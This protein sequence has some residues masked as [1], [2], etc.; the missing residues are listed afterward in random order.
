MRF[1]RP[2]WLWALLLALS[3]CNASPPSPAGDSTRPPAPALTRQGTPPGAATDKAGDL[4]ARQAMTLEAGGKGTGRPPPLNVRGSM[5]GTVQVEGLL[6]VSGVPVTVMETGATTTTDSL[7]QFTF[8]GLL[9]GS[10]TVTV[11]KEDYLQA[12]QR[13]E[14]F[15]G[16]EALVTLPLRR[17]RGSVAGVL[18]LEGASDLSGAIITLVEAGVI[19]TTD[20]QGRFLFENVMTGTY[21]VRARRNL[22]LEAQQAVGVRANVRSQ[23]GLT[24]SLQRGD[25]SGTVRLED[26]ASP[27]GVT[28]TVT[29]TGATATPNAQG[30][31]SFTGLPLGTYTLSAQQEGYDAALQSVTVRTGAAAPVSITLTR[32]R[33]DVAGT[34]LLEGAS[35]HAGITVTLTET[36]ATTNTDAQGR[37][38]LAGVPEGHYTLTARK[39]NY[40]KAGAELDVSIARPASVN[41]SLSRLLEAPVLTAPA[42]A[43]QRGHLRL[44]G[45]H[46]GEER[47][48]LE[49]SVGGVEVEEYVSWSDVEVVVRVPGSLAPGVHEVAMETGVEWRS[50]ATASLR[51]LR[52][53]TLAYDAYWGIGVLPDNTVTVWGEAYS[54]NDVSPIPSGLSDVVSVSAGMFF[55]VAL[56]A[57]GTVVKWGGPSPVPVPAGLSDVVDISATGIGVLAL[58]RD[59]TVVAIGS[60]EAEQM[61]VPEGLQGVVAI[62]A[63]TFHS[64]VLKADGTVTAWG[65]NVFGVRDVPAGL[66]NVVALASTDSSALALRADGTVVV[67]GFGASYHG[68]EA[69]PDLSDV[70]EVAGGS[71]HYMALRANGSVIAWGKNDHRQATPPA[72]LTTGAAVAGRAYNK[73]LALRQDGTIASWGSLSSWYLPP[74]GLVIH[75]PAR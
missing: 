42:L 22:Y 7:G 35:N 60:A 23:V 31:F 9:P 12:Q 68:L 18:L 59:G 40:A 55:A 50:T 43:V 73:S 52:Q 70:V 44:T 28:V 75:V 32:P 56:K 51:V 74:P 66:S 26:G 33:V 10:Y 45:A 5:L 17:E 54:P 39:S 29:Q 20:A 3:A 15:A 71:D 27:T 8:T 11:Q 58:K 21:T 1:V 24:L 14:V 63:S 37:F 38:V 47:G 34:A 30:Q 65:Q 25:V 57:D 2:S 4:E 13:V 61:R 69:T 67:W 46:F 49:V 36:G 19:V 64:L 48:T 62:S 72:S 6:D 16:S 53:R 41:V